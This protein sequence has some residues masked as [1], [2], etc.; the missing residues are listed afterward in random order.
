MDIEATKKMRP[1]DTLY[2]VHGE[3]GNY[4]TSTPEKGDEVLATYDLRV[5]VKEDIQGSDQRLLRLIECVLSDIAGRRI[6]GRYI[7]RRLALEIVGDG[8][9]RKEGR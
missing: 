2:Y 3:A 8:Y 4:I 5:K 1:A 7:A 6:A 9:L